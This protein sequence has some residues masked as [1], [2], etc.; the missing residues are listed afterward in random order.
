MVL[1]ACSLLTFVNARPIFSLV[2]NIADML[3]QPTVIEP[4]KGYLDMYI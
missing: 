2:Q 1:F 4:I 3:F